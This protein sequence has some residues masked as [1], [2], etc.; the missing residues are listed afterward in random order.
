MTAQQVDIPDQIRS[1]ISVVQLF[2]R[3]R[4]DTY[5][6]RGCLYR[7]TFG[8]NPTAICPLKD[9][10]PEETMQRIAA[11]NNVAETAFLILKGEGFKLRWFTPRKEVDLCGHAALAKA[12]IL[13]TDLGFNGDTITFSTSL[14]SVDQVPG[15]KKAFPRPNLLLVYLS[16]L[17]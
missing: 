4:C 11:E 1:R 17:S 16:P 6:S 3:L 12:H 14:I 2:T 7:S 9:W 8:G 10:L 13:F 5:L 15:R